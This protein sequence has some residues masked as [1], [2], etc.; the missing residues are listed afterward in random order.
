MKD[1]PASTNVSL[2][3]VETALLSIWQDALPLPSE[4]ITK[5]VSF[6]GLGGDSLSAMTCISKIRGA[7]SLEFDILDFFV[8]DSTISAFAKNIVA[9][10]D[11]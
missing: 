11:Q 3:D 1:K 4:E 7:F 2:A 8:D 5:D 6:I 9:H 10:R